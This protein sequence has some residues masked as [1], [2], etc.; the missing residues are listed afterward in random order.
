MG[1]NKLL[2]FTAI[3]VLIV[4][5]KLVLA[6]PL[7]D[8]FVKTIGP[9]G[10]GIVSAISIIYWLLVVYTA[11][12]AFKSVGEMRF[13][14]MFR[15]MAIF[16]LLSAFKWPIIMALVPLAFLIIAGIGNSY[17]N[18]LT[19]YEKNI[20]IGIA[21]TCEAIARLIIYPFLKIG[22]LISKTLPTLGGG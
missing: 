3:L 13:S 22:E 9:Y 14:G 21:N 18:S 15:G 19:G 10:E 2:K 5:P 17:A 11:I 8:A 7:I 1:W 16:E 6:Q 20:A 4:L 12:I